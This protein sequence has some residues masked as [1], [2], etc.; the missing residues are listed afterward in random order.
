MTDQRQAEGATGGWAAD[1]LH[2]RCWGVR[3]ATAASQRDAERLVDLLNRGERAQE[4]D[5]ELEGLQNDLANNPD[6]KLP[7][8]RRGWDEALE[9]VRRI[10]SSSA[11]EPPADNETESELM[12][13]ESIDPVLARKVTDLCLSMASFI[14][15][16]DASSA[17]V[18]AYLERRLDPILRHPAVRL[19][20]DRVGQD[21]RKLV[22]APEP[23]KAEAK[24]EQNERSAVAGL[25]TGES[26]VRRDDVRGGAGLRRVREGD[27]PEE[28]SG[29]PDA[30]VQGLARED[31]GSLEGGGDDGEGIH[32]PAE[33]RLANRLAPPAP[34]PPEPQGA[35]ERL[36]L[37]VY[38]SGNIDLW[39]HNA[40][41]ADA[42]PIDYVRADL[43]A[44]LE[45]KLAEAEADLESA[46]T[47]SEILGEATDEYVADA[48]ARVV[49]ERD[50]ALAKLARCEAELDASDGV[51]AIMIQ[52]EEAILRLLDPEEKRLAEVLEIRTRFTEPPASA[53]VRTVTLPAALLDETLIELHEARAKLARYEAALDA[54]ADA[55]E[56]ARDSFEASY[57]ARPSD[58]SAGDLLA[59]KHLADD[60]LQAAR[61]VAAP[62]P[63]NPPAAKEEA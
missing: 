50:E 44:A 61:A 3:A 17:D 38:K 42:E 54:A 33:H 53:E 15:E 4:A 40:D 25:A 16:I 20:L 34:S 43:H 63:P 8:G 19:L 58:E 36:V 26:H 12:M 47:A 31:S 48:A 59:A 6:R 9:R 55:L 60:A 41:A 57:F 5:E 46:R 28:L 27:G 30:R 37:A 10:L 23:G 22:R 7:Q 24:A 29:Q 32:R 62:E 14:A 51:C 52:R 2:V 45:T 13:Q 56:A 21:G 35:P 49:R 39:S 1:G 18:A 11:A